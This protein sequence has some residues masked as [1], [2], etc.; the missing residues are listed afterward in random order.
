MNIIIAT[1]LFALGLM[2]VFVGS[3]IS[4]ATALGNNQ[5][6]FGWG[7]ILFLPLSFIYCSL[8]WEKAEYPGKMIFG[9]LVL[10]LIGILIF[11]LTAQPI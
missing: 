11:I 4:A 8:N 1:I 2:F 7:T 5:R 6:I 10:A 9:G 3:L